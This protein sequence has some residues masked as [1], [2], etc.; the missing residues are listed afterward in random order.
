MTIESDADRN[1]FV[2]TDDFGVIGTYV[3]ANGG[4]SDV[5]GVFDRPHMAAFAGTISTSDWRPT[6][7]VISSDLPGGA[8]GGDAGDTITLDGVTYA[9]AALEPDGT[10]MTLVILGRNS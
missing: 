5:V 1:V 7:L 4:S 2:A 10:G 6:F 9:V 3:A 8:A